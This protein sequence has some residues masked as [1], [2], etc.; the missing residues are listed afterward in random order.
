[1]GAGAARPQTPAPGFLGR[2]E[3]EII[4]ANDYRDT[5][6]D[7]ESARAYHHTRE[8]Q[9]RAQ[10]EAARQQQLEAAQAAIARLAPRYAGIRQVY[11]F[12]SLV[13]PGRFRADS[14]IDVA[15]VCD[16]LETESAFW[17]ALERELQRDVD[18]RPLV[19]PLIDV[20]TQIGRLVYER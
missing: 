5:M 1:M 19:E 17:A 6:I 11:L 13:Q 20:V 8:A 2:Y 16:T 9:R 14:D 15:L 12:G 3:P 18:V 7:I 4:H 10:Q